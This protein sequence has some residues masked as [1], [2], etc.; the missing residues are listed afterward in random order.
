MIHYKY[1][2]HHHHDHPIII[3]FI[4]IKYYYALLTSNFIENDTYLELCVVEM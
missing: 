2:L 4:P 3:F 1:E